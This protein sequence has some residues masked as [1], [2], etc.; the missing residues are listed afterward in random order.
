M[1][2]FVVGTVLVPMPS[3]RIRTSDIPDVNRG[4]PNQLGYA[5]TINCSIM[6]R[7]FHFFIRLSSA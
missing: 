1:G 6:A 4:A 3:E 7:L 2:G 5:P